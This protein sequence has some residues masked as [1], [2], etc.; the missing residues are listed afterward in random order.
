[1]YCCRQ[2]I[3]LGIVYTIK[4]PL[5]TVLMLLLLCLFARVWNRNRDVPHGRYMRSNSGMLVRRWRNLCCQGPYQ[6]W[7]ANHS[8]IFQAFQVQFLCQGKLKKNLGETTRCPFHSHCYPLSTTHIDCMTLKTFV[9]CSN[10]TFMPLGKSSML[11]LF[12]STQSW[13]QRRPITG[14]SV[15][16][17]SVVAILNSWGISSEWMV[18]SSNNSKARRRQRR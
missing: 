11:I 3:C 18:K 6:V 12:E 2:N 1:M 8:S 15:M 16:R 4:L 10:S 5:L 17:T 9:T 14:D 13:K 7:K